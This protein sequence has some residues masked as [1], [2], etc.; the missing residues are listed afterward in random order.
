M[1][2]ALQYIFGSL[3]L[4]DILERL[5]TI[6]NHSFSYSWDKLIWSATFLMLM[7]EKK[8]LTTEMDE[9]MCS[10]PLL[11]YTERSQI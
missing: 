6:I 7:I 5:K 1:I 4:R 3:A 10:F 2:Y 8:P 11:F 9:T